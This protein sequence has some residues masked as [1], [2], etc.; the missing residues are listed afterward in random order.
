[1][2]LTAD[3]IQDLNTMTP[4]A[5]KAAL[6]DVIAALQS[7]G[8][9][10]IVP[11]TFHVSGNLGHDA[12]VGS[13]GVLVGTL[14][15]QDPTQVLLATQ[16]HACLAYADD[17]GA[18]TDETTAANE[19]T[20]D[21]MTLL[22]AVPAAE[23]AYYLGHATKQFGRVDI[24]MGTAGDGVWTITWEYWTGAAW[25]ALSNVTDGTTAFE[26]G[27]A[28]YAVT[29][30]V[31][32]NW[33]RCTVDGVLGYWVRARCS[34]YTSV[35]TPPTGSR[36]WIVVTAAF[37]QC[38]AVAD[39]GGVQT[40]ETTEANE[41][42]GDD[43]TLLPLVP[44]ANDAYYLGHTSRTF[45]EAKFS[46]TTA[47]AGTWTV[48]WEY[49][50]GTA[51]VAL[52]NVVDG[53]AGFTTGVATYS[54]TFT[55]PADWATTTVESLTGYWIR[56]RV[57]VV[58]VVTTQPTGGQAWIVTDLG[59]E[60]YSDDLTDATNAGTDDVPMCGTYPV[61]NDSLYI[62]YSA[63]FCKAV[64]KY[65]TKLQ[66]TGTL[67][68]EYWTGTRWATLTTNDESSTLT[69]NAGTHLVSF[70]PPTDWVA[71]T[72]AN[73]PDGTAAWFIRLRLSA[74]TGLGSR[75]RGDQLWVID[76]TNGSGWV[77]PWA[78][79]MRKVQMTAQTASAANAD[80]EFLL[81][82][83]TQGTMARFTW[84]KA[85]VMDVAGSLT[86]AIALGDALA[87]V[88]VIEDETTEFADAYFVVEFDLV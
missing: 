70:V 23:D 64:V 17:G 46:V 31:P 78:A 63:A 52:S 5:G 26:A 68:W 21:D 22:P 47:G 30:D 28:T 18:Y 74:F 71:N 87:L 29:F 19:A 79:N 80:S 54:V 33:A 51:W 16:A 36:A 34:A 88:Q 76:L 67:L 85:D 77:A 20:G 53:S 12:G 61:I 42:T 82:N 11:V 84:T 37:D 24:D 1:M 14:A 3:Q 49:W 50:N 59:E 6:G 13:D 35:V 8:A 56:G 25:A 40:D 86:L 73:G 81:V 60:T 10:G 2:P 7:A 65:T 48:V 45:A 58:T 66:I 69:A 32:D 38:Q 72:V 4:G 75:G 15:D 44:V 62:G 9:D 83:V 39:D 27:T 55:K 43:M 41:G 57:S